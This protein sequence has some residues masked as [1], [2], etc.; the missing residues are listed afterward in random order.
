ML[1]LKYQKEAKLEGVDS[2]AGTFVRMAPIEFNLTRTFRIG[3]LP[4]GY[5]ILKDNKIF[6]ASLL[7]SIDKAGGKSGSEAVIDVDDRYV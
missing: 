1:G 3:A 2:G 6:S 4:D 7:L 5:C